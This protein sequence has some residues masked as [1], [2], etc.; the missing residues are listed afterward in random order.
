MDQRS[1]VTAVPHGTEELQTGVGIDA[2]YDKFL[3]AESRHLDLL[4]DLVG[5]DE[6]VMV[7]GSGVRAERQDSGREVEQNCVNNDHA[8]NSLE[9]GIALYDEVYA[10]VKYH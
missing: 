9:N 2:G 1:V 7:D 8:Q 3:N 4:H 5:N 6:G 10:R